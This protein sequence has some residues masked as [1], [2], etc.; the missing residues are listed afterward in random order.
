M[1]D[2]TCQKYQLAAL[3][4]IVFILF[5]QL[6]LQGFT[7]Q[8]A[9]GMGVQTNHFIEDGGA[10]VRDLQVRTDAASSNG[11]EE[12]LRSSSNSDTEAQLR[13]AADGM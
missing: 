11:G 4:A 1:E 8:K 9:D 5:I 10:S 6:W 7:M 13:D 12:G 3:I 2:A